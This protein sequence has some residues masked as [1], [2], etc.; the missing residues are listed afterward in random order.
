MAQIGDTVKVVKVTSEDLQFFNKGD[1]GVIIK[2]DDDTEKEEGSTDT[3]WWVDFGQN[4]QWCVMDS[5]LEVLR[6]EAYT[7]ED[8]RKL[9]LSARRFMDP[10]TT[11]HF[12]KFIDRQFPTLLKDGQP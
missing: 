1:V 4:T 7:K 8:M 11:I 10:I 3:C 9:W 12:D 6:I 5:C 2:E